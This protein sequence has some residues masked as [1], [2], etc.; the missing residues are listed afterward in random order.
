MPAVRATAATALTSVKQAAIELSRCIRDAAGLPSL[1]VLSDQITKVQTY[2]ENNSIDVEIA[3]ENPGE[4]TL[5]RVAGFLGC[6]PHFFSSSDSQKGS[7]NSNGNCSVNLYSTR[8]S[9]PRSFPVGQPK[10]PVLVVV[11]SGASPSFL[12]GALEQLCENRPIVFVLTDEQDSKINDLP[13][14]LAWYAE[15]ID[16]NSAQEKSFSEKL[17]SPPWAGVVDVLRAQSAIY[18]VDSIA[19]A[20]SMALTKELQAMKAKRAL[21]Q[22]R[23]QK[24]QQNPA[25]FSANERLVEIRG[26]MQRQLSDFNQGAGEA[27]MR[28]IAPQIGTL[29]KGIEEEVKELDSLEEEPRMRTMLLKI[30]EDFQDQLREYLWQA[31]SDHFRT[32]LLSM[33]DLFALITNEVEDVLSAANGPPIVLNFQYISDQQIQNILETTIVFQRTYRGELPRPGFFE[34]LMM[35]RK[36]QTV[37]FMIFSAF[38]LSFLRR[39]REFMLPLSIILLSFG[40]IY[41]V[42]RVKKERAEMME[43]EI[44]KAKEALEAESRRIIGEVQRSFLVLINQHLAAQNQNVLSQMD[45]ALRDFQNRTSAQ[46]LDEKQKLQRQLQGL[47][48]SEKK[49]YPSLKSREVIGTMLAQLKGELRQII[50]TQISATPKKQA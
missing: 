32:A 14:N 26:L 22:Q 20:F 10:P 8:I 43:K 45:S 40:A 36:S 41:A 42:Q 38:G 23:G 13:F 21:F 18:A 19:D 29:S 17:F 6:D 7:V 34:Y 48:V 44:D 15:T 1:D 25:N 49:L 3:F 47:D 46:A 39:Y 5:A 31:F 9:T 12:E 28:L 30:P 50:V 37:L 4:S 11:L 24:L 27:A 33:R 35:A 2:C 16:L